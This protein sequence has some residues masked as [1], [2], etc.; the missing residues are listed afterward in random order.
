VAQEEVVHVNI[1]E[2]ALHRALAAAS[3]V[4]LMDTG[5]ETAKLGTGK[6]N[7]IAVEKEVI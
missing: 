4:G 7:A 1:S 6:T 5:L 2:E 3:I